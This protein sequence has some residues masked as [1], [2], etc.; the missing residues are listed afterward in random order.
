[1]ASTVYTVE[2]IELFDGTVVNLRPTP[3]K[4]YRIA[5]KKM[6]EIMDNSTLDD[7]GDDTEEQ[8]YE[9]CVYCLKVLKK[10]WPEG[11]EFDAVLDSET[12]YKVLA[13]CTGIDL[14]KMQ[15]AVAQMDPEEMARILTAVTATQENGTETSQNLKEQPTSSEPGETSTN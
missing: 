15:E 12:I 9:L 3:I 1:M 10:D 6:L 13:V 14:K 4:Y 5:N 2:P 8:L 11:Y 7:D